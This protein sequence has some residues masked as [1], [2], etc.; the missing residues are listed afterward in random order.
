MKGSRC[1]GGSLL[2][3]EMDQILRHAAFDLLRLRQHRDPIA[4][5]EFSSV[6]VDL[7]GARDA[8]DAQQETGIEKSKVRSCHKTQQKEQYP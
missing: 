5:T 3:V 7:E 4:T 8:E 1:S 6:L 2:S